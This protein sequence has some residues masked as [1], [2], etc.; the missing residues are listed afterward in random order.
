MVIVV[1]VV[2]HADAYLS[3]EINFEAKNCLEICVSIIIL[4]DF[5]I[6]NGKCLTTGHYHK[7]CT[8]I[9]TCNTYRSYGHTCIHT[10]M[11]A[12]TDRCTHT[13]TIYVLTTYTYRYTHSYVHGH[14]QKGFQLFPL[15]EMY[16]RPVTK[17]ILKKT[18]FL[19]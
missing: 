13:H 6:D 5:P 18:I 3:Y 14:V 12:Y 1:V 16:F 10:Q 11:Y 8:H 4:I 19:F 7:L 9:H 2:V 15:C 17:M